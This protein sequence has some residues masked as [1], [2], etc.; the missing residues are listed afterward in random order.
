[1]AAAAATSPRPWDRVLYYATVST[2]GAAVM[3]IE[4]L[5]TRIIGPFY[6]VSLIVWSSLISVALIALSLGYWLGGRLADRAGA[7]RLSHVV[8][9][10]AAWI[11]LVPLMSKPVQTAADVLGLRGGAFTSA[12]VLFTVPLML[13]GM[14]GPF[15]IK[16]AARRLDDIGTTAGKIYAISTLGSVAGTLALGFFL[17]PV[18]GTRVVLL[19]TCVVLVALS[20]VLSAYERLRLGGSHSLTRWILA[21]LA[22]LAAVFAL[23][24]ALGGR[25]YPEH[26]SLS[27]AETHYGWVRV[28]DQERA[29]IRWLLSDS[30]TIG[31]EHLETG[32]SLLGYQQV[33]GLLPWF[34]PGGTKALLIGLGAG[35]LV[36]VYAQ[37]G[38]ATDAVEI[39]PAVA[40]AAERFFSFRPTGRVVLGDA[41][42]QVKKL[43]TQYDLIV[44]DCF[45]GGAEPIHVLSLEA[46]S[47]L[48][49][50]LRPGGVLAVNFVGFTVEADQKPV[51]SV[52]RTLDRVFRHRRTF[53]SSPAAVFN[54]F[55]FVV[56]DRELAL[57]ESGNGRAVAEWLGRHELAVTGV[58]GAL[59]TDDFNPLEYQQIAKAEHY[60]DLLVARVGKD[61]L[62]R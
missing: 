3:I 37:Y 1:M 49:A 30:S 62:F 23:V 25:K 9:T 41:R 14:A 5:G 21:D 13:L 22:V 36:G 55:V 53:V 7:I 45:T 46:L 52:A 15:V 20:A 58:G 40:D 34:H 2:T 24:L 8:L 42:Y 56:S 51:Q 16:M 18:A 6:G 29:G 54:D 27:E 39:D 35:H 50:R 19:S 57:D 38:I 12:L 26:V 60:R 59:I 44:H 32:T 43:G 61:V 17:L 48:K 10:A 28:I 4:L 11:G 33:V 47:E 31:A